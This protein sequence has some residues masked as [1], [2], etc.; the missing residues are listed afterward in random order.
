MSVH[1]LH[2]QV[3]GPSTP[4]LE[5]CIILKNIFWLESISAVLLVSSEVR[6]VTGVGL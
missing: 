6:K 5:N 3:L 1:S 2:S 4:V